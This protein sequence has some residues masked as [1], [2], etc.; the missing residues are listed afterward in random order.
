MM[1][2]RRRPNKPIS[3]ELA[4]LLA[5]RIVKS[6]E[7]VR[8]GRWICWEST[9][10][11]NKA[12][13]YANIAVKI[14]G[15]PDYYFRH[16][17]MYVH[18]NGPFDPEL[19]I[20]HLC[21]NRACCNPKHLRVVPHAENVLR[22]SRNPFAL[23][24]QQTECVN[25]HPLPERS[26]KKAATRKCERCARENIKAARR[27]AVEQGLPAGDQRHGTRRGYQFFG[28]RC[29]ECRAWQQADYRDSK[30]RRAA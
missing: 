5:H 16:R 25:G 6:V 21:E 19:T 24:A 1:P 2:Q 26:L 10:N 14:N 11:V 18:Y 12:T 4:D 7:R 20:D 15:K 30:R 23:H 9:K 27:R 22:S 28:C 29:D 8:R 3:Q 17:V 13:G